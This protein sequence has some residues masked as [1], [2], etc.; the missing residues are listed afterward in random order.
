MLR[1]SISAVSMT[2][3]C[4][5]IAKLECQISLGIFFFQFCFS[6][7]YEKQNKAKLKKKQQKHVKQPKQKT[8]LT[9]NLKAKHISNAHTKQEEREKSD[10]ITWTPFPS[11]PW[12]NLS[13]D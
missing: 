11:I 8:R 10:K 6:F 1:H 13:F 5:D 3:V 12:K 2:F 7:L 9:Q 4:S